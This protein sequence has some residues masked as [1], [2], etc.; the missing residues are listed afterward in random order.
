MILHQTKTL[1]TYSNYRKT[2]AAPVPQTHRIEAFWIPLRLAELGRGR[3]SLEF[4]RAR[5][6]LLRR[7]DDAPHVEPVLGQSARL[8][9]AH[10]VKTARHVDG[11]LNYKIRKYVLPN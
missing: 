7:S 10:A 2:T 6:G 1:D 11:A 8:V 9:E 3:R 5:D 4:A